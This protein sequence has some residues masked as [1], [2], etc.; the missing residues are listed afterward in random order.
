MKNINF[1]VFPCITTATVSNK[2]I[3]FQKTPSLQFK[4]AKITW[5]ND[6]SAQTILP[7]QKTG[8]IAISHHH[9]KHPPAKKNQHTTPTQDGTMKR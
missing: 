1:T 4:C 9:N 6:F 7:S 3:P 8:D 5:I 2:T